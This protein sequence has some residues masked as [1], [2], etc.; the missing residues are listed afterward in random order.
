SVMYAEKYRRPGMRI[1]YSMQT[2]GT[3]L[4]D[5]WCE[6]FH[7]HEFLIGLSLDG[8]Q[9]LHDAYRVDKGGAPTWQKVMDAAALLKAHKVEFNILTTVHA[10]NM[11]HPLEVYR[12]LRDEVGTQFIQF[13]PIIERVTPEML[14]LANSGWS[15]NKRGDRPLY[16]QAGDL[17]T[18]RSLT[19]EAYGQFLST[20]FDEWVRRD[21]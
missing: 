19:A 11:H 7:E 2:K 10:A 21:V 8:P 16:L 4:D 1:L 18:E 12:F 13:I 20:I 14:P 15:E 9:A 17:V 5:A 6:F 3:L